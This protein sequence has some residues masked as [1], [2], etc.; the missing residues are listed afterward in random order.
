ML[1]EK[2]GELTAHLKATVLCMPNGN[3]RITKCDLQPLEVS[4]EV[5]D[6][7]VKDL[8]SKAGGQSLVLAALHE[9][10]HAHEPPRLLRQKATT[11]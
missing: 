4:K 9:H 7:A 10:G 11:S 8:I 1:H 6:E 3:T 2:P 5:A